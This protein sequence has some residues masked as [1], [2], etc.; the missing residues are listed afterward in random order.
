M[1]GFKD[2]LIAIVSKLKNSFEDIEIC[3]QDIE[4]GLIRPSFLV[5]LDKPK[6][7]GYLGKFQGKKMNVRIVY[8][9]RD[10]IK[11]QM[12][13]LEVQDKLNESFIVEN[14][15]ILG[16]LKLAIDEVDIEVVNKTLHF[17]FK[18]ELYEIYDKDS[19]AEIWNEIEIGGIDVN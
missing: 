6:I 19:N 12:E 9:P 8:F 10:R 5:T 17:D 13:L 16:D 14:Q 2:I 11:N 3:S 1:I 4:E 15:V 18:L 7:K